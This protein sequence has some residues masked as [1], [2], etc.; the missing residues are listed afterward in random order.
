MK[1]NYLYVLFPLPRDTSINEYCIW[2]GN[3][4]INSNTILIYIKKKKYIY[5]FAIYC[6]TIAL[7]DKILLDIKTTKYT[8]IVHAS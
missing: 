1:L 5:I 2:A 3:I 4:L 8:N 6:C 7:P